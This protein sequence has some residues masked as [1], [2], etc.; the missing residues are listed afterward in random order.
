MLITPSILEFARARRHDLE[1]EAQ[2]ARLLGLA[3]RS[4]PRMS[5]LVASLVRAVRSD[6]AARPSRCTPPCAAA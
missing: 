2:R 6:G 1:R 4:R 5:E 3:R